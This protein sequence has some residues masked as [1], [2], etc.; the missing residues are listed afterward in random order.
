MIFSAWNMLGG[1]VVMLKKIPD[2]SQFFPAATTGS[3]LE[4]L[5]L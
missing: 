1:E 5:I 4:V 3:N 2:L